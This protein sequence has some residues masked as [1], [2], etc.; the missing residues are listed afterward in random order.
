MY[1]TNYTPCA[2]IGAFSVTTE[3]AM[4]DQQALVNLTSLG[5]GVGSPICL[6]TKKGETTWQP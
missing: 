4:K 3:A 2:L 1:L 6:I 5:L